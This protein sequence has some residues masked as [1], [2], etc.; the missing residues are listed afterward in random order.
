MSQ[1][2]HWPLVLL[3]LCGILW[4][5]TGVARGAPDVP[6]FVERVA[7]AAGVLRAAAEHPVAAPQ[8]LWR[9]PIVM[10]NAA[11]LDQN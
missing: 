6:G 10:V 7:P 11:S 4:L 8:S 1:R 2:F 5:M 3:C 9:C